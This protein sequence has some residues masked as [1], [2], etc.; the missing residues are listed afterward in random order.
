[1][2]QID[3]IA[4]RTEL[5]EAMRHL[6]EAGHGLL[7]SGNI[8]AIFEDGVIIKPS[9]LS[10]RSLAAEQ[11]SLVALDGTQIEGLKA[12][13]D[14]QSHLAIY[15]NAP[16]VRCVVHT[17]SR[18]ATIMAVVGQPLDILCTM[19]ADYFGEPIPCLR[20]VN[21]RSRDWGSAVIAQG[22]R[23]GALLERHGAVVMGESVAHA[24]ELAIALEEIAAI[25]FH[26]GLSGT[27]QPLADEDVTSLSIFYDNHYRTR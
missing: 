21:H 8:S 1:V 17:H 2:N 14:L 9:G 6:H 24:V 20:F 22:A 19:H 5:V 27:L 26:V 25:A 10:Y 4:L 7:A 3:A 11:L 12:S 13:S 15:R 18:F 16:G 23:R